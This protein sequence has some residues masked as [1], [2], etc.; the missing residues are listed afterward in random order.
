MRGDFIIFDMPCPIAPELET[1]LAAADL[2]GLSEPTIKRDTRA[3]KA[4]LQRELA[5]ST[6]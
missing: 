2:L 5:V 3:A 1:A 4:F 6:P